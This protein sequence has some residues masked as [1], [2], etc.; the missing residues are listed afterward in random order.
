MI[1]LFCQTF[2]Y[3]DKVVKSYWLLKYYQYQYILF[4]FYQINP[5]GRQSKHGTHN[6]PI[7][8]KL[9]F[10]LYQRYKDVLDTTFVKL[11][12]WMAKSTTLPFPIRIPKI[13]LENVLFG[14]W[15]GQIT[16]GGLWDWQGILEQTWGTFTLLLKQLVRIKQAKI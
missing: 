3:F 15:Q 8:F 2:T 5:V 16:I 14:I 6:N 4:I 10:G 7:H 9:M 11:T 12:L 13:E 1:S